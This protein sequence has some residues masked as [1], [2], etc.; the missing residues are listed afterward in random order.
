MRS[1]ENPAAQ[2]FGRFAAIILLAVGGFCG[3]VAV[4]GPGLP[5]GAAAPRSSEHR[6]GII[7]GFYL[8][9]ASK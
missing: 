1:L 5:A 9:T 4:P 2:I 7:P 3:G 6:I 8:R